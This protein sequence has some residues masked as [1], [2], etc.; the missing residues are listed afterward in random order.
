[1]A[2]RVVEAALEKSFEKTI[3]FKLFKNLLKPQESNF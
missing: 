1:M 3:V 2:K